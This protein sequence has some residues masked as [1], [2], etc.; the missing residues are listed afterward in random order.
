MNDDADTLDDIPVRWRFFLIGL[1]VLAGLAIAKMAVST[2]PAETFS[3]FLS[4]VAA[5]FFA[6]VGVALIVAFFVAYLVE[7]RLRAQESRQRTRLK[8]LESAE[9][10]RDAEAAERRQQAIARDVIEGVYGIQHKPSY[11][12][13][14]LDSNLQSMIV[15][16][17][18]ELEYR[19][20]ELDPDQLKILNVKEPN[21]FVV[22][23]MIMIYT[24][25][26]VSGRPRPIDVRYSL[27]VRS[28]KGA[29]EITRV[30][31]A[32]IAGIELSR[33]QIDDAL[34]S[35]DTEND[36]TYSWP[37]SIEG[38]GELSV[39]IK[40]I[41]LKERSD[42]EVGGFFYPSTDGVRIRFEVLPGMVF[43]LRS[44]TNS[45]IAL[46][47]DEPTLKTYAS[48]TPVLPND[49]VV[50]WWRIPEDDA[51]DTADSS[52]NV[53]ENGTRREE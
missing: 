42:N 38:N 34:Q 16:D 22:L 40:G 24:L 53:N 47:W 49:S 12:K 15:R 52:G 45:Q 51:Q 11:V 6:E 10:R 9:R 1:L 50:F 25:R 27:P 36:K 44:L 2:R 8:E 5:L 3:H 43:G 41:A 19:V 29:R 46:D 18:V 4:E 7:G 26:N 35:T 28:G 23:T 33:Q 21:R 39:R 20:S 37:H 17:L 32:K 13:A 31:E 14:V 48:S 30:E